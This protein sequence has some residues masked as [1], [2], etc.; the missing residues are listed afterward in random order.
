[1]QSLGAIGARTSR[2]QDASDFARVEASTDDIV[3]RTPVIQHFREYLNE[4]IRDGYTVRHDGHGSDPDLIDPGG[5]P[6]ETWREDYPYDT[7]ME[8]ELYEYEKYRLQVELLKFQ[9]WAQSSGT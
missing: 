7:R 3:I 5:N 8:R 4:L 1:M 9:Y 6:I 2:D